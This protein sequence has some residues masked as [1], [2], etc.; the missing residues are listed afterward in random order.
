MI[1]VFNKRISRRTFLKAS[2]AAGGAVAATSLFSS[3]A[4]AATYAE[5]APD[6]VNPADYKWIRTVCMMCNGACGI[7]VK[8]N[9]T[10]GI[11]EKIEGNPY[12]CLG[13]DVFLGSGD[14]TPASI[15]NPNQGSRICAK[16]NAGLMTLYSPYRV[17]TPLKR[18]GARGSGV[19]TA[20]AWNEAIN[21]ITTG[22]VEKTSITKA[23]LPKATGYGTYNINDEGADWASI[24][25]VAGSAMPD[26]D[27]HAAV[28]PASPALRAVTGGK[29]ANRLVMTSGRDQLGTPG[30]FQGA[31]GTV[32]NPSHES[33]CN[34][35]WKISH[36]H[37]MTGS[38]G[39]KATLQAGADGP[40]Y[41]ICLGADFNEAWVPHLPLARWTADYRRRGGTLVLSDVRVSQA[42]AKSTDDANTIRLVPKPGTDGALCNAILARWIDQGTVASGYLSCLTAT[43]LIALD[44]R[45]A[46]KCLASDAAALVDDVTG[47][48]TGNYWNGTAEVAIGT[49]VA[50]D[51][52]VDYAGVGKKTVFRLI[53]EALIAI[54]GVS[55]AASITALAA[56]CD[57]PEAQIITIADDAAAAGA[58]NTLAVDG[59]RG[60]HAHT[61]GYQGIRTIIALN[62]FQDTYNRIGGLARSSGYGGMGSVSSN[63]SNPATGGAKIDRSGSTSFSGGENS[64]TLYGT[65]G[66][67]YYSAANPRGVGQ[68]RRWFPRTKR[69]VQQDFIQGA[70]DGYPY[71]VKSIV[72]TAGSNML[73]AAPFG[74]QAD[75]SIGERLKEDVNGVYKVPLLV[76]ITTSMDETAAHCDF[77][78]P[79]VTYFERWAANPR[80]HGY[81]GTMSPNACI[82][83]PAVGTYKEITISG[84]AG[85]SYMSP[86]AT[87]TG[88][89]FADH[90][91]YLA[92]ITGPLMED[93]VFIALGKTLGLP[94]YGAGGLKDSANTPKDNDVAMQRHIITFDGP[95][96]NAHWNGLAADGAAGV[97][98]GSD[99]FT[100][101]GLIMGGR[102]GDPKT[103]GSGG[104][105][106]QAQSGNIN[107][108]LGQN[109]L[110]DYGDA[111]TLPI[112]EAGVTDLDGNPVAAAGYD[113]R[114]ITYKTAW[115]TQTRT[116]ENL[117]LVAL[118]GRDRDSAGTD[119]VDMHGVPRVWL[120]PTKAAA[121]GLVDGDL[122]KITSPSNDGISN[123]DGVKGRVEVTA[124]VQ[125]D[126]LVVDHHYGRRWYGGGNP[127]HG[128][129]N[130]TAGGAGVA[131]DTRIQS[132]ASHAP[133][134]QAVDS[135]G[136]K[137]DLGLT[138]RISGQAGYGSGMVKVEKA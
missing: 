15:A 34:N 132:G 25:G 57:I 21:S 115:H 40:S 7:Q 30:F 47:L 123:G 80:D 32:N 93:D 68:P 65:E 119:N 50:P 38:Y 20:V 70:V 88:D 71:K 92:A 11:A 14:V 9:K 36:D 67:D 74:S 2:A 75:N 59:Y 23:T 66:K 131:A 99:E 137:V 128:Y 122:V 64:P 72:F 90:D 112:R 116:T 62:T 39:F 79:S 3:T 98:K 44:A 42:M 125:A 4:V 89:T 96:A 100:S 126:C 48:K 41:Y 8:V 46:G 16:G 26:A 84:R 78:L 102:F 113:L 81:G 27:I 97:P 45:P 76:A 111:S 1:E 29:A 134:V 55:L 95:N 17:T 135:G 124:N 52:V 24:R 87:L 28:H 54:S 105:A 60:V 127:D 108:Y 77:V 86:F 43:A 106:N 136:G 138:C 31:Y 109:K 51:A 49:Q 6:S 35:G 56:E 121:L 120:N 103:V 5:H 13:N 91:A 129:R 133:I 73:Y 94:G 104:W 83:R 10:T 19:W 33:L 53:K 130:W 85:R 118:T 82:R 110:A 114:A 101:D 58:A 37:S 69:G 61:N 18:N 12:S 63:G 117:W 22:Y 107:L